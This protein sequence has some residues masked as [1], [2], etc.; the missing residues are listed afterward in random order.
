MGPMVTVA[1]L[2]LAPE[3]GELARNAA[4]ASRAIGTAA[5][6]GA[7]VIVLPELVT[8]GYCFESNDEARSVSISQDDPL[9]DQWSAEAGGAVVVAGFAERGDD[10]RL[11][12]SAV[13]IDTSGAR[14]VYRK[15]H[16]WDTEQLFFTAGSAAAPVVPTAFGRIG[17]MV[18][19]DM[20]FPEMTR[21]VALRGADLLV[22][23]TNWPWAQRPAG[24]PAGEIVIAMAAAMANRMPIAC[25]DRRGT[26][27]GQRWHQATTIIGGDG[28]PLATAGP[29]GVAV[30]EVDL[31]ATRHKH[32]SSRNDALGDRRPDIYSRD[33]VSTTRPDG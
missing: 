25:C 18:C 20:E 14:T 8:S 2:E 12:N 3:V 21:S 27:R 31:A 26:E 33:E 10:E 9:F 16:L 1:C 19:Y 13:L 11:Y 7:Q 5:R 30:A 4:M 15:T 6:S 28:W 23:P 17:V 22:V 32:L 29:D 24:M